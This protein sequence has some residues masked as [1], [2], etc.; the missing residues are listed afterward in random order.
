MIIL[1]TNSIKDTGYDVA[2]SCR[3]ATG[4]SA[5][6]KK[7]QSGGNREKW[8]FST[9]VKKTLKVSNSILIN[10]IG[11]NIAFNSTHTLYMD[12]SGVGRIFETNAL[13]RDVSAWYHI[14]VAFNTT[15]YSTV[16]A[17]QVKV[18]V[19]GVLQTFASTVNMSAGFDSG[20]N[21]SGVDLGIGRDE[22][23]DNNYA[24]YYL[25]ETVL[26]DGQQLEADQ[27][28]EF[29]EASGI[30]KPIDVSGLTFGTNGFYLDYKNSANLGNDANGGT[31]LTEGGLAA[32]DQTTDTCTNNFCT[33]SPLIDSGVGYSEGN[34]DLSFGNSSQDSAG[35]TFGVSKGKWYWEHKIISSGNTHY[36]GIKSANSN[37]TSTS[38]AAG[39]P[40]M[41]YT[42][43]GK[44][45]YNAS[46]GGSS[47]GSTFTDNDI[48]GIALDLDNSAIY[49]AKN[50]T[51][52]NSGDPTS[53]GTATGAAFSGTGSSDGFPSEQVYLPWIVGQ[54][55][56]SAFT[57]TT[58]FGNP[59]FSISSGNQ[60]ADGFGNFEYAVPSGYFALCTKN[61][62]E[63]G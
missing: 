31:D 15:D 47:Y 24:D 9:W 30:W 49:F 46:S 34:L 33:S 57:M 6:M 23:G 13:Y 29:D 56:G 54:T 50:G 4:S 5:F 53:G 60:D 14:V 1:G 42:N 37:L 63:Y 43:E 26:I 41:Y 48:I 12:V 51:W 7:A 55:G 36:I 28:G 8:T 16:S 3:F 22:S 40:S 35:G 27:F 20:M 25:A 59:T 52:E 38:G 61:L 18:Y 58:N 19:N 62:A 21:Q 44:K 10:P 39:T 11:V 32:T 2:N 45:V 17:G